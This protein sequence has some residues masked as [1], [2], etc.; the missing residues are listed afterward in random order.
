MNFIITNNKSPLKKQL[1]VIEG[2]QERGINRFRSYLCLAFS[3]EDACKHV[4]DLRCIAIWQNSPLH[5]YYITNIGAFLKSEELITFVEE[6]GMRGKT[7]LI[8][9]KIEDG[10]WSL[11]L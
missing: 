11:F 1:F 4:T 6:M 8:A 9:T 10:H 2:Y 5:K 7:G 3:V